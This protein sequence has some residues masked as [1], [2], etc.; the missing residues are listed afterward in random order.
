MT[1]PKITVTEVTR[2]KI[3]DEIGYQDSD[4]TFTVDADIMDFEVRADSTSRMDG[5]I[6]EKPDILCCSETL[7][8]NTTTVKD[9][10]VEAGTPINGNINYTELTLGDKEYSVEIYVQKKDDGQWY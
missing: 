4:F 1:S 9:F 7:P 2:G 8:C 10:S 5:I 6:V 3:S